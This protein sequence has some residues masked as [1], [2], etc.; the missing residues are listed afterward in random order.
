MY[1]RKPVMRTV[2]Y[3]DDGYQPFARKELSYLM[4]QFLYGNKCEIQIFS[5]VPQLHWCNE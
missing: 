3:L 2:I 1:A 5:L 4:P